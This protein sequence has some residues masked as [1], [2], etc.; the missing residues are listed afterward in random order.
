MKDF[1]IGD[2]VRII[3]MRGEPHY[4]NKVGL[5]EHIDD[6]GQLHGSWGGLAIN[7][8]E[9]KVEIISRNHITPY[10]YIN[11]VGVLAKTFD[12][13]LNKIFFFDMNYKLYK[14]FKS[15]QNLEWSKC[16]KLFGDK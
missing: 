10:F 3:E 16:K 15:K 12:K 11:K 6:I 9:D 8:Q 13:K 7:P 5:V 1:K 4:S 14:G 2:K